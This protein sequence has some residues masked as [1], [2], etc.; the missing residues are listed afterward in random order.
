MTLQL[1]QIWT[2]RRAT[3]KKLHKTCSQGNR[4]TLREQSR[5]RKDKNN[6]LNSRDE[7]EWRRI[8][9]TPRTGLIKNL[10]PPADPA[11]Q[12]GMQKLAPHAHRYP[13]IRFVPTPSPP[14]SKKRHKLV[15]TL[16]ITVI[17]KGWLGYLP[18]T[19]LRPWI[20]FPACAKARQWHACLAKKQPCLG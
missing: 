15:V 7:K 5:R 3:R 8:G 14:S 1:A 16:S 18:P 12:S 11:D 2:M 10:T 4:D 9:I 17:P 20:T 19:K 13:Q 6:K